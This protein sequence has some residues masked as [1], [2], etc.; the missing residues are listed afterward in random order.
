M[1][2]CQG[3]LLA[4]I[5]LVIS[6]A[7]GG[8]NW[9]PS[10]ANIAMETF[11]SREPH[12]ITECV[13]FVNSHRHPDAHMCRCLPTTSGTNVTKKTPSLQHGPH[14]RKGMVAGIVFC[15]LF[16]LYGFCVCQ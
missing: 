14:E 6:A 3:L 16:I 11:A 13:H 15:Y 7:V 12:Q 2:A 1:R 9:F 5:I 8:P 4:I 10:N